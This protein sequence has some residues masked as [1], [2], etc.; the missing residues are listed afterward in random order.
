MTEPDK[1]RCVQH[2]TGDYRF[3]QSEK[4]ICTSYDERE[5]QGDSIY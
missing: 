1:G 4:E 3:I 2:C 5:N